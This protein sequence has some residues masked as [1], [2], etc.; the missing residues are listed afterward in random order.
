MRSAVTLGSSSDK[1]HHHQPLAAGTMREAVKSNAETFFAKR[2]NLL[3]V[4]R[5][6]FVFKSIF[7][8]EFNTYSLA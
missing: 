4:S 2:N 6:Y 7:K 5:F 1:G 8:V 3:D